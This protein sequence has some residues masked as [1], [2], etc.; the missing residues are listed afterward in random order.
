MIYLDNSATTRPFDEVITTMAH[1]MGE[2]YANPA[3]SYA[4][5]LYVDQRMKEVRGNIA[6][7]LGDPAL[8][9]TFTAGGTESNNLAI[10]GLLAQL[11]G[12]KGHFITTA[13]EHP[14]VLKVMEYLEAL[15]H[16][17]DYLSVADHG[18]VDIKQLSDLLTPETT[19]VSVMQVNNETGALQDLAS[20]G[21]VIHRLAPQ[22]LFH[23]D[24]VQS[25][26]RI[27]ISLTKSRVDL[28]SL[29]AHKI[30]GPKGVGALAHNS[31]AHL[32]ALMLGG[33]QE[34]GLRSGT[35]N[36]PGIL[37]LGCAQGMFAREGG[38]WAERMQQQK[39]S[40]VEGL[41]QALGEITI[42]GPDPFKA[43]PHIINLSFD[44]VRG[45]VLLH[46]LEGEGIY[47]STGS[48]CSSRSMKVSSVLLA[49]GVDTE[50]AQGAIRISLCPMTT[51]EEIIKTIETIAA[52]IRRLRRFRRK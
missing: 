42:N 7:A 24:G 33:G 5:G 32:S 44:G 16:R 50:K 38:A 23:V 8:K 6:S 40:L 18:S 1:C 4:A 45:E 12:R 10:C 49:Q 2:Q 48:A 47:V 21:E 9:V 52:Q 19:L 15:G 31:R 27:P 14:S 37:A 43:A 51:D 11:K 35:P 39:V 3:A 46:A 30:H 36:V 20:I 22:C 34:E 13:M 17:V 41:R 25:F 28:Y 26:M 29:S